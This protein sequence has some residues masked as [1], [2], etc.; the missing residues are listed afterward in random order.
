MDV[1]RQGQAVTEPQWTLDPLSPMTPVMKG[2]SALSAAHA[3][4][5]KTSLTSGS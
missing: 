3:D 1:L 2:G 4:V 5:G